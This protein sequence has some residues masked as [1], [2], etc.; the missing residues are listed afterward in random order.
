MDSFSPEQWAIILTIVSGLVSIAVLIA[1]SWAKKQD[2]KLDEAQARAD[3]AATEAAKAKTDADSLNKLIDVLSASQSSRE[4]KDEAFLSALQSLEHGIG[5]LTTVDTQ[6]IKQNDVVI[7][8]VTGT[9]DD[10]RQLSV[11]FA[12]GKNDAVSEVGK[13]MDDKLTPIQQRLEAIERLLHEVRTL[14]M[15]QE[16]PAAEP[17]AP[18]ALVPKAESESEA[19]DKS[20]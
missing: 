8:Q 20:A 7:A 5:N 16:R 14:V 6:R 18:P 13:A 15:Q 9:R 12:K 3:L 17:P 19:E 10:V 1:K 11:D 2:K 4:R